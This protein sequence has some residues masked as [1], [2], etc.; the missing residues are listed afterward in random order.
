MCE[1]VCVAHFPHTSCSLCADFN[2]P[3]TQ[4]VKGF[5]GIKPNRRCLQ[6]CFTGEPKDTSLGHITLAAMLQD[7]QMMLR[8]TGLT[9]IVRF[10]ISLFKLESARSLQK[11]RNIVADDI[12]N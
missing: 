6:V 8:G 1:C 5:Y 2:I 12:N 4:T 9:W 10:Y 11:K 3:S 7:V